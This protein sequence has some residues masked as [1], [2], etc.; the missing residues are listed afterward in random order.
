MDQDQLPERSSHVAVQRDGL[1]RWEAVRG[2]GDFFVH[3]TSESARS[4]G[5]ALIRA[6][7]VA[8]LI[9]KMTNAPGGDT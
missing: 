1:V 3:F 4:L 7:R 5:H 9:K 2:D 6:A 8:D